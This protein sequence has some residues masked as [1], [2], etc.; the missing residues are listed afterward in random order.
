MDMFLSADEL[1]AL[2]GIKTGKNVKGKTVR[3]EQLQADCLRLMG[4][5]FY[6]NARGRPVVVRANIMGKPAAEQPKQAWQP[7]ALRVA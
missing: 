1:V 2:T 4:I 3:R 6:L 5:P 7:R